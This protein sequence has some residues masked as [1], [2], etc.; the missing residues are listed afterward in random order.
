VVVGDL[1]AGIDEPGEVFARQALH[2]PLDVARPAIED[3]AEALVKKPL[4]LIVLKQL[5]HRLAQGEHRNLL[6]LL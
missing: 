1:R 2:G 4:H 6:Q 3:G 5:V